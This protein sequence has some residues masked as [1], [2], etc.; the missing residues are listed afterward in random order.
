MLRSRIERNPPCASRR[1]RPLEERS[2]VATKR[3]PPGRSSPGE[4]AT[5]AKGQRRT[6]AREERQRMLRKQSRVRTVRRGLGTAVAIA[7]AA[8]LVLVVARGGSGGVAFAGDIRTGG[9]LQ[10]LRLPALEGGGTVSYDQ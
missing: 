2:A 3:H 8:G 1:I 4:D 6:Q 9:T 10:S 7:A 5:S